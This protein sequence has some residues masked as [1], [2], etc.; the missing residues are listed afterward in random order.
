[1]QT[2]LGI[3]HGELQNFDAAVDAWRKA[4]DYDPLLPAA[5]QNLGVGCLAQNSFEEAL[6]C[7][8]TLVNLQP[9]NAWH[10]NNLA[11]ALKSMGDLDGAMDKLR[12]AMA[13]DPANFQIHSGLI[14]TMLF[15]PRYDATKV[16][17]ECR[18]WNRRHAA[19]YRTSIAPHPHSRDPA[20]R[21]RVGYVGPAFWAHVVG[22][23]IL[24]VFQHHDHERFEVF[25]YADERIVDAVTEELR[26]CTD[27]W[28]NTL[29]MTDEAIAERIRAD[30]IDI[31]VDL[32]VHLGNDRLP[33]FARRPAPVQV[34]FAGY[35][36]TTGV[37]T[38]DYRLTDP[39][40]DP[41]G[42]TDHFYS[43][44][45]LRLPYSFWCYAP[46]EKAGINE[47]PLTENGFVTF[48]CLNSFFKINDPVL[49]LWGRVLQAVA[50]SR[51][52]MIAPS[53]RAQRHVTELLGGFG[54]GA[55]RLEFLPKTGQQEYLEYYRRID[56][57]LDTVPYNGHTTS[58]DALWMGVP[59]ITIAG[60][61]AV[62]RAGVSQLTNL[63]LT[64]L[65]ADSADAFVEKA[66]RLAGDAG[67]LRE[68]RRTLRP[69]MEASPI[70]DAV[71]F[72]R[73]IEAAYR[74]MWERWCG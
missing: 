32:N 35:P 52:V 36:G 1:M 23:N 2:E 38:I 53:G 14:L 29:A 47:L 26:Q 31:L 70:M 42:A 11:V 60:E 67:R 3:V 22:R 37:E 24:P 9:H 20:R 50:E 68:L 45:S 46:R 40:L 49:K 10:H 41:P 28:R 5:W 69:R 56:I 13:I 30:G 59:V 21:I 27:H 66:V 39:Y 33:V 34:T 61:S 18:E 71:G 25:C 54:V 57:M 72:T 7:Y 17:E 44:E 4:V 62:S 51:L 73:G 8:R 65:I 74:K 58:L 43:E 48:G 63:G 15:H 6:A 19:Q 12:E 16:L 64:E 55:H